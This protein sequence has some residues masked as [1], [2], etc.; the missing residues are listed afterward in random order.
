MALLS[1]TNDSGLEN[2]GDNIANSSIW[3]MLGAG[4]ILIL[5]HGDVILP[6][7]YT[8][9]MELLYLLNPFYTVNFC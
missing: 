1:E 3:L 8:D 9:T 5:K 4:M 6:T 2:R 7:L